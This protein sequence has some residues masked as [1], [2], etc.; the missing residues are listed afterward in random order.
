MIMKEAADVADITKR[1]REVNELIP[2]DG[3]ERAWFK[4]PSSPQ[5]LTHEFCVHSR[6]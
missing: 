4:Y 1:L 6:E 5:A 2:H 3:V